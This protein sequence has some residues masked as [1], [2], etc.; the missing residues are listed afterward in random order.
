MKLKPLRGGAGTPW[1]ACPR[2]ALKRVLAKAQREH[3]ISFSIGYESEFILLQPPTP[4][5]Q[6]RVPPGI[7]RSVYCSSRAYN[8]VAPGASPACQACSLH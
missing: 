1:D 7:D 6:G 2:S 3:G 4:S 5:D 8:D